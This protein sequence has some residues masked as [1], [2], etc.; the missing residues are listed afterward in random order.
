VHYDFGDF[1]INAIMVEHWVACYAYSI[2]TKRQPK[3]DPKKASGLGIPTSY[4]SQLQSGETVD[5]DFARFTPEQVLGK[6]RKGFKVVYA[7]DT[8]PTTSLVDLSA[9][10]DLFI[11]EAMYFDEEKL[12]KAIDAHHMLAREAVEIGRKA[13]VKELWLT[14]FSPSVTDPDLYASDFTNESFN[15]M[16]GKDRY[17][18]T[19][20]YESLK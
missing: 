1:V 12:E 15:V 13:R 19:L 3:F 16:I 6:P 11:C 14:H 10:A 20:T 4:W 7:T 2:E 18:R 9:E 17:C 5:V 8:R